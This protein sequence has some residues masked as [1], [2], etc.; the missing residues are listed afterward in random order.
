MTGTIFSSCFA[1]NLYNFLGVV[2][3]TA[4]FATT[5]W[6]TSTLIAFMKASMSFRGECAIGLVVGAIVVL[7]FPEVELLWD[8]FLFFWGSSTFF[9]FLSTLSRHLSALCLSSSPLLSML[10][11]LRHSN[12]LPTCLA[13]P[14]EG[15]RAL[16]P[17]VEV[18][19]K[20]EA[21]SGIG[22]FF[23]LKLSTNSKKQRLETIKIA[24]M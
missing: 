22:Y 4:F 7:N 12:L 17:T 19:F 20:I 18:A 10:S 3:V 13:P 24:M 23:F 11:L 6:I 16:A 2:A 14:E 8:S 9:F 21:M 1:R 15:F 5:L